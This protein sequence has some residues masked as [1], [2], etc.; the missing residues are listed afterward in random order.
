MIVRPAGLKRAASFVSA[1]L[2]TVCA[3]AQNAEPAAGFVAE[4]QAWLDANSDAVVLNVAAH[5][6]DINRYMD[7]KEGLID[8]I[9]RKTAAWRA[10]AAR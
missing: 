8:E 5:P 7:G 10:R 3:F 6:D 4:H 9:D 1:A 2:T